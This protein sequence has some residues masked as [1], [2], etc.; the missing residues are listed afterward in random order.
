MKRNG[1]CTNISVAANKGSIKS[2]ITI[3]CASSEGVGASQ[4]AVLLSK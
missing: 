3:E 1:P 4:A 2:V